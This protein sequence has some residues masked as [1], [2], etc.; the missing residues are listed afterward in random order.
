MLGLTLLL[1]K[2][3]KLSKRMQFAFIISPLCS[4]TWRLINYNNQITDLGV[5][6]GFPSSLRNSSTG[7]HVFRVH[8]QI[9]GNG[10]VLLHAHS[11]FTH[12]YFT[13]YH[14]HTDNANKILIEGVV[15]INKINTKF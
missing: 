6:M 1:T 5:R 9:H 12:R 15:K 3:I 4:S 14:K 8:I 11:W 13:H 2:L 7:E 10:L